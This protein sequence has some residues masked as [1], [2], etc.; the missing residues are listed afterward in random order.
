[1]AAAH[2]GPGAR[3]IARGPSAVG[4]ALALTSTAANQLG[5]QLSTRW[6]IRYQGSR[7]HGLYAPF[8]T[9]FRCGSVRANDGADGHFSSSM[10]RSARP[11]TNDK[12]NSFQFEDT[13]RD[14]ATA[15]SGKAR[16]IHTTATIRSTVQFTYWHVMLGRHPLTRE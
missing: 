6:S 14:L 16:R 4:G 10:D 8:S 11:T 1:M 5:I 2:D 15:I 7:T 3:R 9:A 13:S 12:P